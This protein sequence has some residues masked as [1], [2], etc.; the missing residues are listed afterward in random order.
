VGERN[1]ALRNSTHQETL[2]SHRSTVGCAFNLVVIG[3]ES[4]SS[5]ERKQTMPKAKRDIESAS[6]S[7]KLRLLANW[8][9]LPSTKAKHPEWSSSNT[10]QQDLRRI[11]DT[12]EPVKVCTSD[13]DWPWNRPQQ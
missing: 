13:I 9:D 8:F 5:P 11:A 10:V 4:G 1:S 3:D 7:D 12:L 6:D 2:L